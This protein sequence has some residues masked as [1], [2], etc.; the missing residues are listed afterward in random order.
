LNDVGTSIH[1]QLVLTV[2][3]A[4]SLQDFRALSLDDQASLLRLNATSL[5]VFA[6][7]QRSLNTQNGLSLANDKLLPTDHAALVGDIK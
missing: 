7:A 2:E 5:I 1:Q 6:V 4:K 3:W